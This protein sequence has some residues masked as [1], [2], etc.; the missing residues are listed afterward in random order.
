MTVAE[1]IADQLY[2]NGV[3]YV[4]GVPGGP[5]IPYMESF[6]SAG[7]E[8]FLTANEAAAGIMATV[9]ARLTGIPG[10]CHATFGPGAV[11]LASGA[12][13]AF[14]DRSPV[15]ILTSELDNKMIHRTTQMNINHQ[16]LFEPLTKATFRLTPDNTADVIV[17]ALKICTEEY[18]GPVHIGLPSDISNCEAGSVSYYAADESLKVYS[19]N[20][21]QIIS[22]LEKSRKPL[23]AAGLTSA[24]YAVGSKLAAL[25]DKIRIPVVLTPMAK[26]LLPEDHPCYAGVLF[27]ALSDYLEDIFR[28]TDLVIGLGYDPVEYNYESWMPDVPLVEFNTTEMDM[29]AL[30]R[31]ARFTGHPD[32]WF[33]I[34]KR[35][36]N[37]SSIFNRSDVQSVR[38]ETIAVFNGFTDH[39]GPVTAFKV[40]QEEL[41]ADVMLTVDVGSHLHLAGQYWN[42]SGKQNIIMTNG[43]SGMGFGIPAALA[44]KI[45]CP[46]STVVCV[47]GDGGFLMTAG[48]ILTAR[49]YNL[50]VIT[51]VLSDGELNLIK[52][53]QSWQNLA[54]NGTSLYSGDL[55]DSANFFG[56]KVLNADSEES[57]RIAV[58]EALSLKKPVI[59]NARIDPDDYKWLVV[60]KQ[61]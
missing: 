55:F 16:K 5:S 18:P 7:I 32:E 25:L 36:E 56:I 1:Y 8:F 28:E 26:G 34:L 37:G 33:S 15:I 12:G 47:T 3:R 42:T 40:L 60:R 48:E 14:L 24:R 21:D 54:P 46:G 45:I 39:F 44:T 59:I 27:H 31:V 57:M 19:N 4:F 61:S 50:S 30:T 51:V 38:D 13:S 58:N 52:L 23:I 9:S 53:K 10:V 2:K 6:R 35:M 29:P 49:R 41:P 43:W 22:L 20:T 17:K 11:N